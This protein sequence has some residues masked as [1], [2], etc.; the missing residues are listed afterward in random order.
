MKEILEV[1]QRRD[2][3]LREACELRR[4]KTGKKFAKDYK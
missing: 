3:S 1:D 2:R 4:Q